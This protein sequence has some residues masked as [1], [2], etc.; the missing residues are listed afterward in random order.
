MTIRLVGRPVAEYMHE[1]SL[2]RIVEIFTMKPVAEPAQ[3]YRLML[4]CL[5]HRQR[6]GPR[7]KTEL[8][9]KPWAFVCGNIP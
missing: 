9:H 8:R 1:T 4:T 5:A 7:L 3:G 2:P 6:T